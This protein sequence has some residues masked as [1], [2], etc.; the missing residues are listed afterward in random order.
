MYYGLRKKSVESKHL[1]SVGIE[2]PAT[3]AIAHTQYIEIIAVL[4][5]LVE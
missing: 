3:A 5:V 1:V 4:E 2:V